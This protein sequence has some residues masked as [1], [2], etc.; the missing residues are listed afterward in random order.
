MNQETEKKEQTFAVYAE[1]EGHAKP[2]ILI[3]LHFARLIDD[4]VLPYEEDK[5][6]FID[7]VP[8]NRNIIKRLKIIKEADF[9]ERLFYNLHRD[10]RQSAD[11][12]IYAE[13]YDTRMLALLRE[14]GED[15]TSQIIKAYSQKIKPSIKNYLPK[16]EELIQAAMQLFVESIKSLGST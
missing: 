12:K 15:V 2:L 7:G 5:P 9:F 14:S 16:R 13:Q 8:L 11:K 3:G 10:L 1:A 4:I 6:F